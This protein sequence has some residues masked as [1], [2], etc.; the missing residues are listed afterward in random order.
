MSK[1]HINSD[2]ACENAN[3]KS[4][5]DAVKEHKRRIFNGSFWSDHPVSILGLLV[6]S[7]L[8]S[9]VTDLPDVT[10]LQRKFIFAGIVVASSVFVFWFI[11]GLLKRKKPTDEE[12]EYEYKRRIE[13][14]LETVNTRLNEVEKKRKPRSLTI[15]QKREIKRVCSAFRG[16]KFTIHCLLGETESLNYA[17]HLRTALTDAGWVLVG[18]IAQTSFETNFRNFL[19]CVGPT[20]DKHQLQDSARHLMAILNRLELTDF[21]ESRYA[22]ADTLKGDDILIQVSPYPM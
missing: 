5:D 6:A 22:I 7:I 10:A 12:I 19:I 16:Q 11:D 21:D 17:S 3:N 20:H 14:K 8:V 18:G 13:S 4:K 15:D 9:P 2:R 1:E